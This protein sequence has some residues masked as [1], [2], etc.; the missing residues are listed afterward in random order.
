MQQQ[1]AITEQQEAMQMMQAGQPEEDI[2]PE[3]IAQIEEQARQDAARAA[4][5]QF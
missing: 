4:A 5:G 3:M 2:P 1:T